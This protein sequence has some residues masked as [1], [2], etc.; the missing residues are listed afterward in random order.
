MKKWKR[1]LA[2]LV[3][4][5]MF[6]QS[7]VVAKAADIVG[8]GASGWRV[9][10]ITFNH[11]S[12]NFSLEN[13]ESAQNAVFVIQSEDGL[14]LMELPFSIKNATDNISIDLPGEDYLPAGQYIVYVRDA[15]AQKTD[16][17]KVYFYEHSFF[18]SKSNTY[19]KRFVG[20]DYYNNM[21]HITAN[22]GFQDYEGVK[23]EK[24]GV[25]IEY[26]VQKPGTSIRV[27]CRDDYGCSDTFTYKVLDEKARIPRLKVY[28]DF[29]N[30]NYDTL[31]ADERV[32]AEFDGTVYYSEYGR[33]G[34]FSDERIITFPATE[35][36]VDKILIWVESKTKDDSEK[37]EYEMSDCLIKECKYNY[38]VYPAKAIGSVTANGYGQT[39]QSV[40]TVINGVE[41][42][43]DVDASGNFVLEYPEHKNGDRL[44]FQFSDRHGCVNSQTEPVFNSTIPKENL[45]HLYDSSIL[46]E[47]ITVCDVPEN[48]RLVA[49]ING[50]VYQSDWSSAANG[51]TVTVTYPK[52]AV[53]AVVTTWFEMKDSSKSKA[54][55]WQVYD[56]E[57]GVTADASVTSINGQIYSE[58]YNV[59]SAYVEIAGQRYPCTLNTVNVYDE[60]DGDFD[61]ISSGEVEHRFSGTYPKQKI[62][63]TITLVLEDED[64]YRITQDIVLKNRKPKLS[65]NNVNSGSKKVTGTTKAKSAV[66]VTIG[67]K[68]YSSKANKNGVF[69]V[70]IKSQRKTGTKFTVSVVDPDGYTTSKK[71]KVTSTNST[72]SLRQYVLR[73]SSS[74]SLSVLNGKKGDKVHV[75]VGSAKYK[76]TL[77]SNNK[78]QKI[79]IPLKKKGEAGA[80]VKVALYDKFGK[81]KDSERDIVYFGTSIYRGM[82]AKNAQLTTWGYPDRRNDWGTGHIQWVFEGNRMTLYA[83][84]RNGVVTSVQRWNY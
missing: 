24:G 62:G 55:I 13:V 78:K 40:S 81:K 45:F 83:Y 70:N 72:I 18:F 8:T 69:S 48:A 73:T 10:N 43:T 60:E 39:V 20:A 4:A 34:M 75:S 47:R 15:N 67:K 50:T 7:F 36:R 33:D 31:G 54:R 46:P 23:D 68:K 82:S 53:G 35:N 38:R 14:E 26:P 61:D 5:A 84:I 71:M 30:I 77:K 42:K 16:E 80:S 64:G 58:R 51:N 52:Q 11:K 17:R 79:T 29:I 66:T 32:C 28:R 57:Y 76:K 44:T 63:T 74:V 12:V 9:Y 59:N 2:F 22:V 21:S 41:Y 49:E 65:V 1:F 19:T 25:I 27:E 56:K 6:S 3:C 37:R